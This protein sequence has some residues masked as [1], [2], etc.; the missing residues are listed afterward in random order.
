MFFENTN[1]TH[2]LLQIVHDQK[3]RDDTNNKVKQESGFHNI[4]YGIKKI[5]KDYYNQL[6]ANKFSNLDEMLKTIFK[7][8]IY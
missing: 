6:Y 5:T 4:A 1:K 7:G 3:K 2:K 8:I